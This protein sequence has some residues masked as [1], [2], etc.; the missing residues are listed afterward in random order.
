MKDIFHSSPLV[1]LFHLECIALALVE[2]GKCLIKQESLL[3]PKPWHNTKV[4]LFL[5]NYISFFITKNWL[6]RNDLNISS[7]LAKSWDTPFMR[8]TL[9]PFFV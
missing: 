4:S 8:G 1:W 7:C 6:R 3:L 5:P 9:W 2:F